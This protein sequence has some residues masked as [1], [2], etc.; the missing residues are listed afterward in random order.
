[1]ALIDEILKWTE[2]DLK[3]WQRCAARRLFQ[4]QGALSES[5]YSE[6]YALLK[7]AN[8]LPNPQ[9]L[10][11]TP[12]TAA[13]IPSSLTSGQTI[14]FKAMRDLKHVNRIAPRQKLQ[15]SQTGLTVIYGGNG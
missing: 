3:P 13:H 12:L 15:F 2:T 1:M 5:D 6:L 4:T 7:I 8:G 10:T 11:P 14:V 9:K